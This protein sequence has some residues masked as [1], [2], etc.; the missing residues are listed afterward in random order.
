[1]TQSAIDIENAMKIMANMKPKDHKRVAG[2]RAGKIE[3]CNQILINTQVKLMAFEALKQA[4]TQSEDKES[5]SKF[6]DE[7]LREWK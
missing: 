3:M 2:T 7:L 5:I 4:V 1:M 6:A